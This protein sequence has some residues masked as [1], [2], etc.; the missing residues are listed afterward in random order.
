MEFFTLGYETFTSANA[1]TDDVAVA[2]RRAAGR[3]V[4]AESPP[5]QRGAESPLWQH[6]VE[7]PPGGWQKWLVRP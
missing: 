1:K 6:D 2:G 4:D 7:S 3:R 5:G